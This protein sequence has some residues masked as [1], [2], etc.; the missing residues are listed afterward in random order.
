[1]S[2]RASREW[3]IISFH[4]DL[5]ESGAHLRPH[6]AHFER[7][8]YLNLPNHI[9][10]TNCAKKASLGRL[11]TAARAKQPQGLREMF[12]RCAEALWHVWMSATEIMILQNKILQLSRTIFSWKQES[13]EYSIPPWKRDPSTLRQ[14]RSL[15]YVIPSLW[16]LE[17]F[18]LCPIGV[19][20]GT[21]CE[22]FP[23]D[24]EASRVLR[25]TT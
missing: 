15:N 7:W 1:M 16:T 14:W 18:H 22:S 17:K 6:L 9:G 25:S 12:K 20:L 8:F 3:C 11:S 2:R 10:R 5:P 4:Q 21:Q 24:K 23:G 19:V 13:R